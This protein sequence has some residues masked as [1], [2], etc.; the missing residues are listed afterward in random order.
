MNRNGM[1]Y[2]P[3]VSYCCLLL[4]VWL[5]SWIRSVAALFGGESTD[6]SLASSDGVRWFLR[7]SVESVEHLPWAVII[8]LL[9]CSGMLSSCGLFSAFARLMRGE[10]SMRMRRALWSVSVAG[11][12]VAMLLLFAGFYP[13]NIYTSVSGSFVSSPVAGGWPLLLFAV[14]FS[15]S[16]VFGVVGGAFRGVNDVV[17]AVSSRIKF[18]ACSLVA[19][20]PGALLLA[21][22]E[23]EGATA[24]FFGGYSFCFEYFVIIFPFVYTLLFPR[25]NK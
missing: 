2:L 13:L 16:A 20:V 25:E 7:S 11:V 9:M 18:H 6:V 17:A 23:Y 15:L 19:L 5:C 3:T 1:K 21:S 4:V 12:I 14:L 10:T 8:I 24:M 22:M